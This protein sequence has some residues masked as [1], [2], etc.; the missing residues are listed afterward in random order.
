MSIPES[1]GRLR[2]VLTGKV[3][4]T[5]RP[6]HQ[7][8]IAKAPCAGPVDVDVLGLA[9]DAQA[10]TRVH[11]GPHKA[12]HCYPWSHYGHWRR[13]LPSPVAQA[14]LAVPG[15]FGENFSLVP[16]LDEAKVCIGD[17]WAIGTACFEVSQGRQPCWKLDERFG[18]PGMATQ[19]QR[20]TRAGWY[21][22]VLEPGRVCAGDP[23]FQVDR[24][25]PDWPL[26]RLLRVI[27]DRNCEPAVLRQIMA[28]PL[29]AS[30]AKLFRG[31]LESGIVED[32]SRR[33]EGYG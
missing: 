4:P 28:L 6:G 31:R 30:W 13:V 18:T 8:A 27:A 21:L 2:A 32:W 29:P 16:G 5:L 24:P 7:T 9:G 3:Q 11:G 33:M 14:V 15:A 20:S 10:D 19:V 23:I 22:R 25:H 17:R 26:R 12:V 1:V